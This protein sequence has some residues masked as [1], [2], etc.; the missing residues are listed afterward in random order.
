M[1]ERKVLVVDRVDWP[2]FVV[3]DSHYPYPTI[4]AR[5]S[6]HTTRQAPPTTAKVVDGG[7]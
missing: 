6:Q 7:R 2:G 1:P 4:E 3:S 5:G